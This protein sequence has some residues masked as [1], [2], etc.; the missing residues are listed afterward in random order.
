M[1][2][3]IAPTDNNKR[4]ILYISYDVCL[5]ATIICIHMYSSTIRV[6]VADSETRE[7]KQQKRLLVT[8][9]SFIQ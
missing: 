1:H 4:Y 8:V 6:F 3:T 5:V 2:I 7:G 9:K